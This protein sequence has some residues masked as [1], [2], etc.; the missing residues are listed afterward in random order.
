MKQRNNVRFFIRSLFALF[1][2]LIKPQEKER[3]VRS[4]FYYFNRRRKRAYRELQ[5]IPVLFFIFSSAGRSGGC[6][7]VFVW[8]LFWWLFRWFFQWL[9]PVVFFRAFIGAENEHTESCKFSGVFISF[10]YP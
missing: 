2:R 8:W 4:F 3:F 10:F 9:Y 6:S 7:G 5:K 1:R